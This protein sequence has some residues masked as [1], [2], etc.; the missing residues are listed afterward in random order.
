[1]K[2]KLFICGEN[3]SSNLAVHNAQLLMNELSGNSHDLE[4]VDVLANPERA[5]EARILATPTFI[6][7]EPGPIRM[8]VGDL[9]DL[10]KVRAVLQLPVEVKL[11]ESDGGH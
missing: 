5:E 4:V 11:E 9:S 10:Q 3:A 2:F 8:L 1:M 6:K 7:L